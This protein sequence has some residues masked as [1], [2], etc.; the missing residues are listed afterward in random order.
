MAFSRIRPTHKKKR[1]QPTAKRSGTEPS[2]ACG[3]FCARWAVDRLW[4]VLRPST[5]IEPTGD[6]YAAFAIA[7]PGD[8]ARAKGR[9]QRSHTSSAHQHY[10]K[11][12]IQLTSHRLPWIS[13]SSSTQH[14]LP[15]IA[16][17]CSAAQG[18][19]RGFPTPAVRA[20]LCTSFGFH[21]SDA[22]THCEA[23]AFL[24]VPHLLLNQP[25]AVEHC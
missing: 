3:P 18:D 24:D 10:G 15:W 12:N 11:C 19:C 17:F 1:R 20:L 14:S 8:Q 22:K 25:K 9:K 4:T 23:D 5:S 2:I 16:H 7:D 6:W 21:C 13:H